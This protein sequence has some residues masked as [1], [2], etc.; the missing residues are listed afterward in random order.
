MEVLIKVNTQLDRK[1]GKI[2]HYDGI[3]PQ[4]VQRKHSRRGHEDKNIQASVKI[5]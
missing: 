5:A 2:H 4:D 3:I 1:T